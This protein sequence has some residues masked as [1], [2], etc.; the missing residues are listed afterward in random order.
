[1]R[2]CGEQLL[3]TDRFREYALGAEPLR[4]E[5]FG[6]VG[7]RRHN[8]N[9]HARRASDSAN[10]ARDLRALHVWQHQVEHDEIGALRERFL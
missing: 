10:G 6:G 4:I 9:R 7:M 3:I 5:L 1:M 2:D 8:H